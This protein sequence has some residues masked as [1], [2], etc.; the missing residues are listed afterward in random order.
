MMIDLTRAMGATTVIGVQRGGQRMEIA[1][2]YAADAY[3]DSG[4]EDVVS[5]CRELTGGEGPDIVITSCASVEGARA[6]H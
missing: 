2:T 5:R 3:V 1:K 4:E 6:G